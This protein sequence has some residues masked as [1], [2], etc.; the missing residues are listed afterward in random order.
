MLLIDWCV[1]QPDVCLLI[2]FYAQENVGE[3]I[4]LLITYPTKKSEKEF[5][6]KQM[7]IF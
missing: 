1:K 3:M 4:S 5:F 7:R 6:I 2:C